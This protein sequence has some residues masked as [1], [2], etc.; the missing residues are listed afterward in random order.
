MEEIIEENLQEHYE[1]LTI[2][3]K[4]VKIKTYKIFISCNLSNYKEE[5]I[6][7]GVEFEFEWDNNFTTS[8]NIEQIK[9]H[10]NKS[11]IKFFERDK[12]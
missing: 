10:I 9:Y 1:F 7:K 2:E 8:A 5:T 6:I 11:I 3:V 4:Y 12:K